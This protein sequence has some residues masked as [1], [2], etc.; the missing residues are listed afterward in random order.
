MYEF[1]NVASGADDRVLHNCSWYLIVWRWEYNLMIHEMKNSL[2][3]VIVFYCWPIML[4]QLSM[5]L[6]NEKISAAYPNC[7]R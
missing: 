6:I 5:Y 4:H 2:E 7:C 1:A 3:T